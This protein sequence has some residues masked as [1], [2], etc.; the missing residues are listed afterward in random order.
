[1]LLLCCL[2]RM[3][4]L[5]ELVVP[6]REREDQAAFLRSAADYIRQLQARRRLAWLCACG[7]P[8]KAATSANACLTAEERL[9]LVPWPCAGAAMRPLHVFPCTCE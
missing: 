7:W 9:F 8:H 5:R 3:Q 1:M 2:V 4:A 6:T